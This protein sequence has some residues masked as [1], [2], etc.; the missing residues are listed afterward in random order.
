M[1]IGQS[2]PRRHADEDPFLFEDG[3]LGLNKNPDEA[4]AVISIRRTFHSVV[5]QGW[6]PDTVSGADDAEIEAW[7]RAQGVTRI[8]SAVREV[9]S[10]IGKRHGIWLAGTYFGVEEVT[11]SSKQG[12]ISCVRYTHDGLSDT[13]G[14]LVI[15]DHQAYSYDI[16]D[17]S[18]LHSP[19]PPV[20]SI[21][22]GEG[23]IAY[24]DSTSSWFERIAPNLERY[25]SQIRMFRKIGK[26]PPQV[27]TRI[28][29]LSDFGGEAPSVG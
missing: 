24:Y 20:W 29:D 4:D 16:I 6:R 13:P 5:A 17:G 18:D 25:R 27:T 8:P 14:M 1:A 9:L 7:A 11:P 3:L 12:A 2:G 28:F 22:E 21:L 26:S 15:S 19:D 23:A 10:L